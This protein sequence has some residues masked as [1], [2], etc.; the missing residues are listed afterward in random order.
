M[1]KQFK[2]SFKHDEP[3]IIEIPGK[4]PVVELNGIQHD[5]RDLMDD[6]F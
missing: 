4:P 2:S 3:K 6:K 5:I 1:P